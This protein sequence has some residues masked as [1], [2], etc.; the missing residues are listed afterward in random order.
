MHPSCIISCSEEAP[1]IRPPP[2]FLS[3]CIAAPTSRTLLLTMRS[4]L[5]SGS[6]LGSGLGLGLGLRLG[7]TRSSG[8][9]R[10]SAADHCSTV[11][12]SE[13][14]PS[15]RSSEVVATATELAAAAAAAAACLAFVLSSW[16][17]ASSDAAAPR[18]L[19]LAFSMSPA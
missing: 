14:R 1:Y 16:K 19:A 3:D 12:S 15:P 18:S 8:T 2:R 11:A 9:V 4:W 7:R 13:I 17:L 5:G 10:L 6:G